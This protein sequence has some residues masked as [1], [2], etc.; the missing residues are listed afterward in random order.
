[1]D[2]LLYRLP[3][4]SETVGTPGTPPTPEVCRTEIVGYRTELVTRTGSSPSGGLNIVGENPLD[5]F[6]G[7]G[8]IY[9][10]PNTSPNGGFSYGGSQDQQSYTYVETVVV[11]IYETFC[12]GG[13][14]GTEGEAGSVTY[15]YGP[16]WLSSARS[17]RFVN[18]H[19]VF[20][21]KRDDFVVAGIA[22]TAVLDGVSFGAVAYGV[23]IVGANV[24]RVLGGQLIDVDLG[25]AA[26]YSEY[27]VSIIANVA[28]IRGYDGAAWQVLATDGLALSGPIFAVALLHREDSTV[29]DPVLTQAAVKTQSAQGAL[30][31]TG[32]VTTSVTVA[33]SAS[34]RLPLTS[35]A[36]T[37]V[38]D[39]WA[40]VVSGALPLTGSV[41]PSVLRVGVSATGQLPLTGSVSPESFPASIQRI[42]KQLI[43]AGNQD[44]GVVDYTMPKMVVEADNVDAPVA[45][46]S[47]AYLTLG[48]SVLVANGLAGG[49]GGATDLAVPKVQVVGS[50]YD[51]TYGDVAIGKQFLYAGGP[52]YSLDQAVFGEYVTLGSGFGGSAAV[53]VE[54]ADTLEVGGDAAFTILLD[55]GLDASL[56]LSDDMSFAAVLSAVI[57]DELLLAGVSEDF[58][59]EYTQYVFNLDADGA[60]ARFSGFNYDGILR[61]PEGTFGYRADGVYRI[62]DTGEEMNAAVDM[63]ETDFGTSRAKHVEVV[64]VGV[65]ST[66]QAI[67]KITADGSERAYRVI[68]RKPTGKVRTGRGITARDWAVKLELVD[69][70][71]AEITDVEFVVAAARRWTR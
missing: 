36:Q 51:Y 55:A 13:D 7:T 48:Q 34:G 12:T 60:A 3:I 66:G 46:Y 21:F 30:P 65:T 37:K 64:F 4:I 27:E 5:P 71:S 56:G 42:S 58:A 11:P 57:E 52:R 62:T 44:G 26:D 14:A 45:S 19:A 41:R 10:P 23:H 39:E 54:L 33:A 47:G 59:K 29:Y 32:S 25:L 70:T 50:D 20:R 15:D 35:K 28:Q 49:I 8:S 31:I 63:G 38:N 40:I 24:R 68:Q 1:M 16:D 22:S 6:S 17:I 43:S 67:L 2:N 61:T 9:I 18:D 53:L 69:V